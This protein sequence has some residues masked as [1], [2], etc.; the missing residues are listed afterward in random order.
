MT[1]IFTIRSS[2]IK[3]NLYIYIEYRKKK[4]KVQ[5]KAKK[6]EAFCID[7][8]DCNQDALIRGVSR[9]VKL[10]H[11]QFHSRFSRFILQFC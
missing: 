1:H 2:Q 9:S 3:Q 4:K 7:H 11:I 6:C 8:C 10:S 5:R